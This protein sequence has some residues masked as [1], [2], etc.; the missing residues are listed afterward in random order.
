MNYSNLT[1]G[2]DE[3]GTG[4]FTYP[5]TLACVVLGYNVLPEKLKDSKKFSSE[6]LREKSSKSVTDHSLYFRVKNIWKPESSFLE[7]LSFLVND[8]TSKFP[9]ITVVIDGNNNFSLPIHAIVGADATHP[10]VSAASILAKVHRDTWLHTFDDKFPI[11]GFNAN[12]GY[13]TPQHKDTI[14]HFG[15]ISGLH[16]MNIDAVHQAWEEKGFYGHK[17]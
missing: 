10:S 12:K 13:G 6:K 1:A 11:Y 8:V 4:S 3:V 5:T 7:A 15:P 17:V 14:S 16:R 2:I 9:G